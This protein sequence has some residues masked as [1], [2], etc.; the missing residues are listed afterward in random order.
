MGQQSLLF[1]VST[2]REPFVLRGGAPERQCCHWPCPYRSTTPRLPR[3]SCPDTASCLPT[4]RGSSPRTG[5]GSTYSWLLSPTRP[6]PSRQFAGTPE[7]PA[8]SAPSRQLPRPTPGA[9]SVP[10]PPEGGQKM[11]QSEG[12]DWVSTMNQ[13]P[14][15]GPS[16]EVALLP[17]CTG[18]L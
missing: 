6:S 10:L 2:G 17:G 8:G 3:A 14:W 18:T 1:Q 12:R 15:R 9:P 11:M 5:A 16:S 7:G 13:R 4:S